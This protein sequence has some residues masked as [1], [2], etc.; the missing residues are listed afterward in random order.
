[1][2]SLY[3][4]GK[5]TDY[6]RG[7]KDGESACRSCNVRER[8]DELDLYWYHYE[9]THYYKKPLGLDDSLKRAQDLYFEYLEKENKTAYE[10]GYFEGVKL[11]LNAHREEYY[12]REYAKISP[13]AFSNVVILPKAEQPQEMVSTNQT[14][15]RKKK[16]K[17]EWTEEDDKLIYSAVKKYTRD[18]TSLPGGYS[19]E[20]VLQEAAQAW[21]KRLATKGGHDPAKGKKST[22][23]YRVVQNTIQDLIKAANTDKRKVNQNLVGFNDE[24]ALDGHGNAIGPDNKE[25]AGEQYEGGE[26][27][28]NIGKG[29]FEPTKRGVKDAIKWKRE[30]EAD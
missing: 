4:K 2:W 14:R 28:K 30:Q 25:N 6:T 8:Y 17:I 10:K 18:F 3:F 13:S 11:F 9:D 26:S 1:L 15:P 22:L 21:A 7:I 20:D 23:L 29:D 12:L 5:E 16:A 19:R 24:Y 27:K